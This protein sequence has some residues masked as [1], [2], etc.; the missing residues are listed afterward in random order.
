MC[1]LDDILLT[2]ATGWIRG[3]RHGGACAFLGIPYGAATSGSRRFRAPEPARPWPGIR[4]A[5]AYAPS[6]PQPADWFSRLLPGRPAEPVSE[7][8]LAL[9]VWTPA[10]GCGRR[11]V[12]LWLHGGLFAVGSGSWPLYDGAA[13]AEFGDVVVVTVN[14]RLDALGYLRLP[15]EFGDEAAASGLAGMLDLVLA[16]GW[17][18]DNI[19]AFGGDPASVTVFGQSGGAG[20]VSALLAMPAAAGLFRRAILQS[21]ARPRQRDVGQADAAAAALLAEL[22]VRRGDWRTLSSVPAAA[23]VTAAAAVARADGIARGGAFAPAADG[24]TLLDH[25][26]GAMPGQPDVP[27]LVGTTRDEATILHLID[28]LRPEQVAA[29]CDALGVPGHVWSAYRRG[30]PAATPRELLTAVETDQWRRRDARA[31]ADAALARGSQVFMYRF[32]WQLPG[33]GATHGAELPFVFRRA[34]GAGP[35]RY[36]WEHLLCGDTAPGPAACAL[37]DQ[38]AGAWAAFARSGQP[39]AAGLP[40]W[41]PYEPG[42]RAT[43]LLGGRSVVAD[44]PGGGEL[45]AWEHGA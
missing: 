7:D 41:P 10:P 27:L 39:A 26:A 8:C 45:R 13:L 29:R 31:F 3:R 21:G 40:P 35:L 32:D 44:D 25:P 38:L 34:A 18:R 28:E 1:K 17:V 12:M 19:E 5:T 11:P 15:P 24:V 9:N 2:T 42:R 43:M 4:D 14:H 6:C 16:L 20:K 36:Q 37:T 22:G 23:V 30:R 33:L